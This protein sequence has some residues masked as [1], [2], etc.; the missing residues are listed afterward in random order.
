[1]NCRFGHV[2][3]WLRG[4]YGAPELRDEGRKLCALWAFCSRQPPC[5][6]ASELA[7]LWRRGPERRICKLNGLSAGP[8][9]RERAKS[10]ADSQAGDVLAT[11][12]VSGSVRAASAQVVYEAFFE[13]TSFC[14]DRQPVLGWAD[15]GANIVQQF[16]VRRRRTS[17]HIRRKSHQQRSDADRR[18]HQAGGDYDVASHEG[19]SNLFRAPI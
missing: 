6:S 7:P 19:R 1:M 17:V 9:R 11:R 5:N 14:R 18:R 12:P 4:T 15:S 16:D 8:R 10:H 13:G 2:A 3:P